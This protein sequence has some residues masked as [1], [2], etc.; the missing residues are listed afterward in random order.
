M[1]CAT[2]PGPGKTPVSPRICATQ[3]KR[4][5]GFQYAS[6]VCTVCRGSGTRSPSRRGHSRLN[7]QVMR[8]RNGVAYGSITSERDARTAIEIVPVRGS[9]GDRD[10]SAQQ[11]MENFVPSRR[12]R[13]PSAPPFTAAGPALSS[14]VPRSTDATS[15][16]RHDP[17]IK[18]PAPQ[19]NVTCLPSRLYGLPKRPN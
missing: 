14:P 18:T 4:R 13:Y 9:N 6:V 19:R 17:G 7:Y 8:D 11:T 2:K 15:A 16:T 5:G 1:N 12:T 3:T 10:L